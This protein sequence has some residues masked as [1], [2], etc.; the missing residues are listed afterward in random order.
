MFALIL[1]CNPIDLL[2]YVLLHSQLMCFV[3]FCVSRNA[4]ANTHLT[5]ECD[6]ILSLN[7]RVLGLR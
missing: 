5:S 2:V 3:L 7:N 4:I 1:T 6:G